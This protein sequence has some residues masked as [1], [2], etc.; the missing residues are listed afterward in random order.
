[1]SST[2]HPPAET[3]SAL[4]QRRTTRRTLLR[5]LTAGAAALALPSLLKTRAAAADGRSS[6]SFTPVT[7]DLADDHRVA[8]GHTARVLCSWG[9]GVVAGAP[10]FDPGALR[11]EDQALQ[12]GTC[13]DYTAFL[14]LPRG[15]RSSDHGLLCVNHEFSIA[16][17][18]WKKGERGSRGSVAPERIRTEMAAH[19][20][21]VVEIRRDPRTGTWA[22]VGDSPYG[23]RVT[24]RT[25]IQLAGP[26]RG[27]V[28]MRTSA[29]PQ[30]DVVEGTLANCAGGV[31]PWGTVL[32]AEENI[33][34]YFRGDCSAT[35]YETLNH[36]RFG[37]TL[38]PIYQWCLVDPRFDFEA[39]PHEPNR[40]GW[41]VELDPYDPTATPVKRTALGRLKHEGA[42][43]VLAP[44]G[45]VV[46]YSGDDEEFQFLYRY[47][48][49]ARYD[50]SANPPDPT[51]LDDGT[52]FVARFSESG[53]C[54]WL[55][56]RHGEGPLRRANG[57]RDQGEVLI[58]VRRAAELLGA[59]PMD[60]PEDIEVDPRTGRV[61]V[62]LTNNVLRTPS[63]IEGPN[64][65]A[66]NTHGQVL[67]L[68]PPKADHAAEVFAW[69][70]L[71]TGGAPA[72][73]RMNNPDNAAFDPAGRL[74]IATDQGSR[75][76]ERGIA[77]GLWACETSGPERGRARLFYA[78][79]R[80]AEVCGP[81]F[82]PDGR[83][84]F[85]A[86]QHPGAG[87]V[88]RGGAWATFSAPASRWPDFDPDRPPRCSVV[89]IT[90]NDGG[91]VGG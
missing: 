30:G 46:V 71:L 53:T 72:E 69:S 66:F 83:T 42:T 75:Q 60:R 86:V 43:T 8:D 77:D 57:F 3:L 90:R 78:A 63:Q 45:R 51:L 15:S 39:E 79:P 14:P 62:M 24:A 35:G 88:S 40:F 21:S 84:L 89:A 85:L 38:K 56:L 20:H 2:Q 41:I 9:D 23:R 7:W 80:G 18:M 54:H 10:A 36:R 74:W 19:G 31:T 22:R 70:L 64:P 82:T 34:N 17:M 59:T 33:E 52:L 29:D 28:R 44:D 4:A 13:N 91:P 1:M 76:I 48:S 58:D 67:E 37:L 49:R 11:A 5:G 61:Y 16:S 47:V 87:R 68:D 65:R 26:A 25:P 73:G 55:P 50:P 6:F 81:T 27:H 32:L 12:F